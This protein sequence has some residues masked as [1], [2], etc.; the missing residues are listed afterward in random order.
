MTNNYRFLRLTEIPTAAIREH[1]SDPR[2]AKH[3][4]L[5]TKTSWQDSDVEA[6]I[7]SK[8]ACWTKDGLGHWGILSGDTYLGWGGFQKEAEEWDFGL[9]LHPDHFGHGLKIAHQAL[10]YAVQHPDISEVTFLLAPSRKNL[11][12]LSRYGAEFIGDVSH[13]D[14]TFLKF[15]LPTPQGGS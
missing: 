13:A 8:E 1:M 14:Q 9:V 10:R 7:A 5:M 15:R 12:A 2:V 6:L 4:P 3:L 11:S